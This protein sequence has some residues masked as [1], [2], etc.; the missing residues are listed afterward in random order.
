[1]CGIAGIL[2]IDGEPVDRRVLTSM[3][4]IIAHRGPDDAG[5]HI[6]GALGL[7]HRRLSIIDLSDAGHQPMGN[8]D[9]S[10][11]LIFNGEIY[12]FELLRQRLAACGHRF[13][14]G[15]DTEVILHAYEEWGTDCLSHFN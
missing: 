4:D 6:D 13:R 12:N 10:L 14:S 9:G 2:N 11:W 7:G 5:L 15:T 3:R 8:E 1:M